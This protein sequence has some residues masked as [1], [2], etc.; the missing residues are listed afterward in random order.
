MA[1]SCGDDHIWDHA[2]LATPNDWL[3]AKE[4]F[5]PYSSNI[6]DAYIGELI[7]L[8]QPATV[9]DIGPGAGKYGHLLRRVSDHDQFP[10]HSTAIEIDASYV[11]TYRLHEVYDNV[12]I[13]DALALI[14]QPR[15]R[16]DL[17]MIG[18][19]IEHKR[20]S[21]GLD[22]LNFLIYRSG[23][24]CVVYPDAYI[25]DDWEDHAAEAHI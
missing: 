14:A 6:F 15:L 10:T 3:A 8:L 24:I 16:Y 2:C 23:Y 11:E 25:Q 20:K 19:C 7:G 21:D 18:D 13:T 9:C 17:V 12:L 5:M 4:P 22:L 1:R